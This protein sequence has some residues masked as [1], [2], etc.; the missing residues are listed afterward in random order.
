[1]QDS[2]LF[3]KAALPYLLGLAA[4][5]GCSTTAYRLS[6]MKEHFLKQFNK[7]HNEQEEYSII[8][9]INFLTRNINFQIVGMTIF[10]II[11]LMLSVSIS[12]IVDMK[13]KA[14]FYF[15]ELIIA[16]ISWL[17]WRVRKNFQKTLQESVAEDTRPP[18]LFLRSFDKD[19][20]APLSIMDAVSKDSKKII[21][22]EDIAIGYA[23]MIGPVIAI[24]SPYRAVKDILGAAKGHF[25]DWQ[26]T[27]LKYMETASLIIMR[28][29]DSEGIL[30]EFEQ[31]VKLNY[32]HKTILYI[33]FGGKENRKS[34]EAFEENKTAYEN[35]RQAVLRDYDIEMGDYN[36]RTPRIFFDDQNKVHKTDDYFD[37]PIFRKAF[38][39]KY[40][41]ARKKGKL[42]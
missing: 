16:V 34:R 24:A 8:W 6:Q 5:G 13:A 11:I 1:M 19:G 31:L 20:E 25:E 15:L 26:S 37:I 10:V 42:D 40:I 12:S 30:W 21:T 3:L 18:V 32:L 38:Y 14:L 2:L 27:I 4:V 41:V 36:Q 17:I 23:E 39:Q 7:A 29:Y 28:P 22:Y 33:Y 35:F 9:Y